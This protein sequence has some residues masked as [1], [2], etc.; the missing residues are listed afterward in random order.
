MRASVSVLG[1]LAIVTLIQI[2]AARA[3]NPPG[4]WSRT[5]NHEPCASFDVLRKPYFGDTHVH[6]TQSIDAVLFNTLTTPR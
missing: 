6:T 4:Q 2:P 1:T 3:T 5:E